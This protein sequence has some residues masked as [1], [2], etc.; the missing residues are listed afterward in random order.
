MKLKNEIIRTSKAI[1]LVAIL[2]VLPY[3]CNSG[4]SVWK[5]K[6]WSSAINLTE[7]MSNK[8]LT[9]LS[10]LHWNPVL[11]RLYVI[12]DNGNLHILQLNKSNNTFSQIAHI[13]SLGGPEGVMQVDYK[14][15]EFY[16]IDEKSYEIRRY[17]HSADFQTVTLANKWNLQDSPCQM[18]DTGNDGC[19]GIEFVPDKY[20]KAVG[21]ISTETDKQY[22]STKGMGGLIFIAH[23]KKGYVWV[24][25]VN[26]DKDGDY[27]F[28][29]RYKTN[30]NESCDLAFDRSTGLMYILHNTNGNSIEVTDLSTNLGSGKPKFVMKN[31]YNIPNPDQNINIEGFAITP[32]F[33]DTTHVSVWLCRDV[34]NN[35]DRSIK[36]DCI[37]WFTPFDAEGNCIKNWEKE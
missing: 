27:A 21:F 6:T 15:N 13:P 37:R 26:P 3:S 18:P 16:T 25:D 10:G 11:N 35:E 36:E 22:V 14:T 12:R 20:L 29:G 7:V 31:E 5:S 24:F 9:E 23:Q 2:L 1:T 33:A 8:G 30:R 19:E 17:K 4:Q 32:K 34:D 28:V